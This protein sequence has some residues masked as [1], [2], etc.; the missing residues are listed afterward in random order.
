MFTIKWLRGTKISMQ[1]VPVGDQIVLNKSPVWPRGS[2]F[3][4]HCCI[5]ETFNFVLPVLCRYKTLAHWT[6]HKNAVTVF[7]NDNKI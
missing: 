4:D 5:G 7:L 1:T 3:D 6:K 2:M